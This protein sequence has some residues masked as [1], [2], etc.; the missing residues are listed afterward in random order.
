VGNKGGVGISLN[1]DGTTFLLINAH[2]A[3]W[4][5]VDASLR[6]TLIVTITIAHEGKVPHRLANLAKIKVMRCV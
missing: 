6:S 3:G 2:L 4:F 5:F 1:I